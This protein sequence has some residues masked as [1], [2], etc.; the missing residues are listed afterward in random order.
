MIDKEGLVYAAL[1]GQ[2]AMLVSDDRAE[3]LSDPVYLRR[4]AQCRDL[5]LMRVV[6]LTAEEEARSTAEGQY[7][8]GHPALFPDGINQWAEQLHLSQE[9]A[10]M[11]D[12]IAELD[13]A[14]PAAATG[15]EAT[16]ARAA[17]LASDLIEPARS[18][19]LEKLDEGRLA[20]RIATG[21]LRSKLQSPEAAID[22]GTNY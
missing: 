9:L 10:V 2:L 4:I 15:P 22:T 6:E 17:T 11:A 7:L 8:A 21:W 13:G 20:H 3:R 16:A 5:T 18:S 12:R 14:P 1:A 19:A